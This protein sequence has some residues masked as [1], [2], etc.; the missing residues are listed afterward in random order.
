L[1]SSLTSIELDWLGI[2]CES[3]VVLG[4]EGLHGCLVE[5]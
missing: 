3:K 2:V 1:T 5:R 4:F